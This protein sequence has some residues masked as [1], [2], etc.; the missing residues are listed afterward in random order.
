MTSS[1]SGTGKQEHALLTIGRF[2][3]QLHTAPYSTLGSNV[4]RRQ[5]LTIPVTTV[6]V[7]EDAKEE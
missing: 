3:Y 6:A 7:V 2:P 1:H 5:L 4:H